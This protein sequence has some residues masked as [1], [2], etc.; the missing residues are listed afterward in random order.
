[1]H[2]QTLNTIAAGLA[3]LALGVA[4][5]A[6]AASTAPTAKVTKHAAKP[7]PAKVHHRAAPA[8]A[9]VKK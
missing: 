2:N 7:K 4:G 9:P 3:A 1:M 6:M 8:K 5:P